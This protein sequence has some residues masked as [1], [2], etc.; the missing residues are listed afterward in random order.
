MNSLPTLKAVF[1]YKNHPNI[2]SIRRFCHQISNFNFSCIVKN[3]VLKEIRGLSTTK[4]SQDNDLPVKIL[5]ENADY[6]AEFICI[7]FNDSVNS[8]KFPSSFKCANITPIFKNE[9]RNHK[10]NYR[11]VSILPIVSK[12]FEKIMSNLSYFEKILSKF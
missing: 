2:F 8:S 9:S 6:F 10:A 3:T 7:Q 1:K 5:K 11:P 12:I 4:A